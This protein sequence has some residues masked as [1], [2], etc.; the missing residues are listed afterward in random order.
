M[1]SSG[2]SEESDSALLYINPKSNKQQKQ[3]P[4]NTEKRQRRH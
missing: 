1:L 4:L 2:V 3:K